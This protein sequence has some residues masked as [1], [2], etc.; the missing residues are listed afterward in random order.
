MFGSKEIM[1]VQEKTTGLIIHFRFNTGVSIPGPTQATSVIPVSD[2][3]S[4]ILQYVSW[5]SE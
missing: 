2:G 3:I 4:L 5:R 1:Y